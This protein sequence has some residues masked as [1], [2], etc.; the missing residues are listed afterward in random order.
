M[1]ISDPWRIFIYLKGIERLGSKMLNIVE[2]MKTELFP[3]DRL[4][5]SGSFP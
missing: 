2:L 4:N 5:G 3:Y 1:K